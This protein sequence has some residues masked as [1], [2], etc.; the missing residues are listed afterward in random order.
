MHSEVVTLK[1]TKYE[2]QLGMLF[3]NMKFGIVILS[4]NLILNELILL[5]YLVY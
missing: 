5:L 4:K 3:E 1:V 2:T